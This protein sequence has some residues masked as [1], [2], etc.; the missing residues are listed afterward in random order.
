MPIRHIGLRQAHK[1]TNEKR[2][3]GLFNLLWYATS[4]KAIFKGYSTIVRSCVTA[5]YISCVVFVF[6]WGPFL[7]G[8][9]DCLISK[10]PKQTTTYTLKIFTYISYDD[11]YKI[12]F[13]DYIDYCFYFRCRPIVKPSRQGCSVNKN[14]HEKP[15]HVKKS[16]TQACI[17]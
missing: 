17:T 4:L 14:K 6:H 13:I 12:Q 11:E 7:N 9:A 15:T 8:P 3:D 10:N 16:Q 2:E 1:N 5:V